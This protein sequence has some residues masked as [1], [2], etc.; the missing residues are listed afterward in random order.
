[1]QFTVV[2]TSKLYFKVRKR[3]S[4]YANKFISLR[5]TAH[6]YEDFV[7]NKA[8]YMRE[9]RPDATWAQL[10]T[11]LQQM[12]K[13]ANAATYSVNMPDDVAHLISKNSK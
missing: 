11:V 4:P 12:Q 1:M 13:E 10:K 7:A 6:F 5:I 8:Q 9:I 2:A 3:K